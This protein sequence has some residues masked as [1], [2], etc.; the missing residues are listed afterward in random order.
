[1]RTKVLF[2]SLPSTVQSIKLS[3]GVVWAPE[4][5]YH[6]DLPDDKLQRMRGLP[7]GTVGREVADV[8]D[9]RG[10]RL[11]PKFESHDLKHV[12]LG[13][14]MTVVDEI[15]MQAYLLGNGNYTLPC[16]ASVMPGLFYPSIW[17]LLCNDF[18]QGRKGKS[19]FHLTIDE[20]MSSSLSDVRREYGRRD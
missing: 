20:C 11:I 19:I 10:Y 5:I 12:I 6:S 17:K 3:G 16:L 7:R 4:K 8:L 18:K 14:D 9:R 1:M 13:Y 2:K 15:R